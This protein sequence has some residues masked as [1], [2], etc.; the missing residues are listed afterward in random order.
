MACVSSRD[1]AA[2]CLTFQRARI[3]VRIG[4][5][6]IDREI[7]AALGHPEILQGTLSPDQAC[8]IV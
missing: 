3:P 7:D 2:D 8:Q 6:P 1:Q 4:Q 5:G